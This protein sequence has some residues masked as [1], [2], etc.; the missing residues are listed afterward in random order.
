MEYCTLNDAFPAEHTPGGA[1]VSK[2]DR[3]RRCKPPP[4]AWMEVSQ[5]QGELMQGSRSTAGFDPSAP[6]MRSVDST[7]PTE[8]PV[9]MSAY[10]A[11][12]AP[13]N[14]NAAKATLRVTEGPSSLIDSASRQPPAYFGAD[15]DAD[16]GTTLRKS[17]LEGF[18]NYSP[19]AGKKD[20]MMETD[21]AQTFSMGG[22]D[23][24]AGAEL[25]VP[26][27][28]DRW[29]KL[30]PKGAQS[31]FFELLPAPGG[32]YPEYVVGQQG[33]IQANSDM[34]KRLDAIFARLDDLERRVDSGGENTQTEI[35]LFI[36]SGVFVMFAAD[37]LARR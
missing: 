33:G 25:P 15:P 11:R 3:K 1:A 32:S 8:A 21:F 7:D 29:K 5:E 30:T 6:E 19:I 9:P 36:L 34:K 4:S 20:Y 13:Q 17:K 2:R 22:A 28:V 26:S 16:T 18:A 24:A 31:S 35:F 14:T 27:V 10:E 37:L 23:K 12:Q